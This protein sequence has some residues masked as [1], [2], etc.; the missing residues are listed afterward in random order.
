MERSLQGAITPMRFELITTWPTFLDYP[1]F[2]QFLVRQ[3]Y[4]FNS[5]TISLT[6]HNIPGYDFSKAVNLWALSEFRQSSINHDIG[7][8][9]DGPLDPPN[10]QDWR[11]YAVNRALVHARGEVVLFMEQ[12]F[13]ASWKVLLPRVEKSLTDGAD[14]VGFYEESTQRLHPACLFIKK[15]ILAAT[16]RDFSPYQNHD[17]FGKITEDLQN[18]K[19]K[20]VTFKD[21]GMEGWKYYYHMQG[22]S[23]NYQRVIL[24]QEPNFNIPEFLIYNARARD[25]RSVTQFTAFTELANKVEVATSNV[26]RILTF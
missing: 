21:L 19:A 11:D 1:L 16:S 25:T 22:L 13:F 6:N 14:V 24:G 18:M 26:A 15:D 23:H 17:H 9:V 3:S 7:I 5:V 10:N 2:R 8:V 12:D 4:A 20:I